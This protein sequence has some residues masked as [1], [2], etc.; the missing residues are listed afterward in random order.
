VNRLLPILVLVSALIAPESVGAQAA[1]V[2][3]TGMRVWS[4]PQSTRVVFDLSAPVAYV[5]PDSGESAALVVSIPGT[6]ITVAPDL[7]GSRAVG[8][9]VVDSVW[10]ETT[11]SGILF[12]V[13]MPAPRAFRVFA[14]AGE[15]EAAYRIVVDVTR[16]GGTAAVEER[17]SDIADLKHN[18]VRVVAV[19][20]G[21][22]G[23]DMGARGSGV[24][25]KDVTLAVARELV[26]E[27]NRT[28][29]IKG[30]L[31]RDGDY[32]IPLT[33]RYRM[34][35]RMKADLF[36]SIH[37]NS[38]RR[39]GR[40]NKG[41]EVYFLS[42]RGASDQA[43]EDL[44]DLENA[45]DLVGGV[46]AQSENELVSILYD[47]KRTSMLQQSQILAEHILDK[48]ASDRRLES[49]G[50]KQAAFV[51][52]KSVEHPSVLVEVAFINNPA[53]ARLLRD[54]SFQR[55]VAKQISQGV[56]SYFARLGVDLE[57]AAGSK[58]SSGGS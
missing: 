19:D 10:I 31:T 40:Q 13:A 27:L 44:A 25:E 58:T 55:Q 33:E 42:L 57:D 14:L 51:V 4:G 7:P 52:L 30:A 22:G 32:F 56:R 29:G 48:V 20:A 35:E 43:S 2:R 54:P 50:I 26:K 34:A 23:E 1:G 18:R 46:P 24:R 8:D 41:T 49:R 36:I 6:G 28:A 15:G 11:P 38:S 53:E 45:A 3:F 47:V 37:A 21:H 9:T 39:R 17:L 5:A 12:H 16:P